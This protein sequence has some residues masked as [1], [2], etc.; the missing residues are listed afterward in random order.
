VP[1][2]VTSATKFSVGLQTKGTIKEIAVNR[3]V[4]HVVQY[5]VPNLNYG[6]MKIFM[7]NYINVKAVANVLVQNKPWTDT[8]QHIAQSSHSNVP[9]VISL[10]LSE[11]TLQGT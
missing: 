8:K 9:N 10:L 6:N 11:Q 3:N 2:N 4:C 7:K 5:S 1:Q